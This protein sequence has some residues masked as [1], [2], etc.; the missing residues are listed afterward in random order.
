MGIDFYVEANLVYIKIIEYFQERNGL[1][2]REV[3]KCAWVN[4]I[5][6]KSV[7]QSYVDT[8]MKSKNI[9]PHDTA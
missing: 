4:G 6:H 7:M 8:V 1:S 5:S 2:L 3:W 9:F